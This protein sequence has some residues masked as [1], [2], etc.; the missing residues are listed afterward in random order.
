MKKKKRR[1]LNPIIPSN[2]IKEKKMVN[3][4]KWSIFQPPTMSY[5]KQSQFVSGKNNSC[6]TNLISSSDRGNGWMEN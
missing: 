3:F 2:A 6:H 5:R 1:L 4:I